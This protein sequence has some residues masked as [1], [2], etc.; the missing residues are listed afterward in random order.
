MSTNLSESLSEL[1][2]SAELLEVTLKSANVDATVPARSIVAKETKLDHDK[3]TEFLLS[4]K[5]DLLVCFVTVTTKGLSNNQEAKVLFEMSGTFTLVYSL[6]KTDFTDEVYEL[7]A[8][9]NA[10]YNAYPYTREL[11]Q[12]LSTR[13]GIQPVMLPLLKPTTKKELQKEVQDR[14]AIAESKK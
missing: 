7:F 5:K 8:D 2:Q 12:S 10:F 1:V 6:S 4:E 11:F 9:K 14:K 13:I 3:T